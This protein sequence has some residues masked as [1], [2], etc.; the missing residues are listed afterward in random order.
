MQNYCWIDLVNPTESEL[1]KVSL[2]TNI[3]KSLILKVLDYEE[4]PRIEFED[5]A[6]LIV[7]DIPY[8]EDKKVKNKYST[9]PLGIIINE[10]YLLTVCLKETEV[11]K[12]NKNNKNKSLSTAKRTRFI[13]QLLFRIATYYIRYL[14]MINSEIENKE[15]DLIKSTSNKELL[16]LMH[17]QKSLVYFVTSL[18]ANAIILEKLS[19]GNVLNLYEEDE[20]LLEDAIIENNQ[21]IETANIYREIISSM[22][23]TYATIISNNLNTVMKFLAGITIVLSIPTIIAS[24][25][26][27]NVDLGLLNNNPFAFLIIL[28]I[29]IVISLI[30]AFVLKKKGML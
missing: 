18:K 24:F 8:I 15:K 19:K 2:K 16:N 23:D 12:D 6:T 28:L 21:G 5:N 29:S 4:L 1:D 27:M 17:I 11:L 7:V 20:D 30:I 13:I 9:I 10:N 25:M 3:S 22:S 14:N 26:G